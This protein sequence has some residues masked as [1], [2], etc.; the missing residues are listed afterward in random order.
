[1]SMLKKMLF[2]M[3]VQKDDVERARKREKTIASEF[4]LK[5]CP[6]TF[7]TQAI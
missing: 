3:Y 2:K 6:Q 4:L 1:M 7:S 5:F